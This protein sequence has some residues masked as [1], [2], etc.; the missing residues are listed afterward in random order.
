[1]IPFKKKKKLYMFSFAARVYK[2]SGERP[3]AYLLTLKQR[4]L[5]SF[6]DYMLWFNKEKL[7][8]D[9]PEENIVLT[10]LLSIV[11]P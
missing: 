4:E 6:K 11:L 9:V 10:T 2:G 5:D 1:V 8:V 3:S 7:T